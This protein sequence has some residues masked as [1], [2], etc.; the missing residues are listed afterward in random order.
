[1][2]EGLS[3]IGDVLAQVDKA[4]SEGTTA[5][6]QVWPTGFDPLDTYL[7]GGLRSGELALLGGPQGL[8]KT[9]FALQVMRNVVAGGGCGV[10]FSYE[11]DATTVLE[12]LVALEASEAEGFEA[13]PLRRIR[14]AMEAGDGRIGSLEERLRNAPGGSAAVQAVRDYAER[15]FVHRSSGGTTSADVIREVIQTARERSGQVPL[16]VVDYLQKVAVPDSSLVEEERVTRIVESLKD[17]ALDLQIPLFVVVAADREGLKSGK[18][19]RVHNLR[20]S[21]ALAYEAD[22]VLLMNDKYDV[23]ARHHLVFGTANAERFHDYAVVS[24]EK[25]RTGL[26][27]IDLEFAKRF[28]QGRFDSIGRPVAEQLVD[29]RV[30]IE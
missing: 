24:I 9:T 11:H 18:R 30:F 8:G 6:A 27:K 10:Y 17:L 15:L 2:T 7:G 3:A 13:V 20:G 16:V 23:V 28:E 29:E 1:V 5:A 25:N 4:L 14:Q 19:L 26:D 22:V 12:R 21:S